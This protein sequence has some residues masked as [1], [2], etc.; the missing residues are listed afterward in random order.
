MW[1]IPGSWNMMTTL[2]ADTWTSGWL[3]CH[4]AWINANY[5]YHFR[6]LPRHREWRLRSWR[7]CFREMSTKPMVCNINI[8]ARAVEGRY[9]V[10]YT[11]MTPTI[12][13]GVNN[14][15]LDKPNWMVVPGNV[16]FGVVIVERAWG[17]GK[18]RGR[19]D[20][21]YERKNKIRNCTFIRKL[22][23]SLHNQRITGGAPF[24]SLTRL[25]LNNS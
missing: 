2:S 21:G 25:L 22:Y 19:K 4:V 23:P 6:C 11:A 1:T 15:D 17:Q 7:E 18:E 16:L 20:R 24:P 10:T 5:K 14:I 8:D 13:G 9:H 3:L 12:C